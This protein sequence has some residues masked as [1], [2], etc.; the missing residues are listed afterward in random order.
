MPGAGLSLTLEGLVDVERRLARLADQ[1]GDLT[2]LMD[3][4][5]MEIEVDIEENFEGEHSPAGIRPSPEQMREGAATVSSQLLSATSSNEASAHF[6]NRTDVSST[7][8]ASPDHPAKQSQRVPDP[9][10][11]QSAMVP[12]PLHSVAAFDAQ[13]TEQST[14]A[15]RP[16]AHSHA[17]VAPH[18]WA[19][20]HGKSGQRSS[21]R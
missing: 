11:S 7:S 19:F 21:R 10:S 15:N 6:S 5:G 12:W 1:L 3:I 13:S 17:P 20:W 2:P 9:R 16:L 18:T 8:H 4:L 14:P